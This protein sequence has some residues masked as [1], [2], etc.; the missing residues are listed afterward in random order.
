[1]D[2]GVDVKATVGV[3]LLRQNADQI[4]L[5]GVVCIIFYQFVTLYFFSY[6]VVFCL[7][8]VLEDR[9]GWQVVVKRKDGW[10]R[11]RDDAAPVTYVYRG[12]FLPPSSFF[13][14]HQRSIEREFC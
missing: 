5:G 12:A 9:C 11:G 13:F 8:T 1:M 6:K 10:W 4:V 14:L 2:V 3:I 7:A